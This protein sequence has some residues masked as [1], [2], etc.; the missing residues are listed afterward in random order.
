MK[1]RKIIII[2]LMFAGIAMLS[3]ACKK[4]E[5]TEPQNAQTNDEVLVVT[6]DDALADQLFSELTDITNEAM[7]GPQSLLKGVVLDTIFMGPCVTVTIDTIG[8][9]FTTTIDF[10]EVNCLCHD[11]KYR[12]GKILVEHTGP[13]WA[14]G[15]VVTTTFDN[16]FVNDNQLLG[17]KVVTNA[18]L[19]SQNNM[20]WTIEVDGQVIK[21]DGGVVTWV[22]ER[23]REW[24]EGA[25]TPMRWDNVYHITGT[26]TIVA[27]NGNTMTATITQALEVALNC[28]WIRS[29]VVEFE[30][31]VFPLMIL[32]YGD[33]NCDN[34][35]TVTINGISYDITLRR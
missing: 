9:P 7:G 22:G 27:S 26:H 19:N 6:K 24:V 15:T 25:G 8:F 30:H 4:D 2:M 3:T 16:Y 11:G 17:T 21:A 1:T 35:A 32:D 34:Q 23:M 10:G 13:Y 33:G 29:G 31:S 14:P 12:R 28:H 5:T 20:T 18:G